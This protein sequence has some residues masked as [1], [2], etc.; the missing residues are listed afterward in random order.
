M[1]V[2]LT[3]PLGQPHISHAYDGNGN[4]TYKLT[5][6][7]SNA[8]GT[9]DVQLGILGED[10]PADGSVSFYTYNGFG[11]LTSVLVDD[12]TAEYAYNPSGLRISKTVNGETTTHILDGS[13]VVADVTDSGIS[14]YNRGREL[15]SIEQG[16]QK[17]YY[18][19]NGHG[20]VTRIADGNGQVK[21]SYWFKAFGEGSIEP[22][23]G[24]MSNPFGYCGEYTDAETG[25]IYLRARYYDPGIGRFV[26]E[27]THQGRHQLV[28]VCRE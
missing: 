3:L 5:D 22:Y 12:T 24:A 9:E 2:V 13:N 1:E 8:N 11:E 20:D 23:T 4:Q 7:L 16:G 19:F 28:F 14:K 26:S 21:N 18:L 25:N 6:V 27:D 10:A 17:G 15:I